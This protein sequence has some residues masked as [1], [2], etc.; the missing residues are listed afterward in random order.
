MS[1]FFFD[2]N[3]TY[4]PP[5]VETELAALQPD[6][7]DSPYVYDSEGRIA[8]AINMALAT[9]RPLMLLGP[10]GS[11]KSSLAK[12]VAH[13]FGWEYLEYVVTAETQAR[14]LCWHF[15]AVSRLADAQMQQTKAYH[16]VNYVEPRQLW[17]ALD[18]RGAHDQFMI[19]WEGRPPANARLPNPNPAGTVVLID[20]IDKA[21]PSVPNDLLIPLGSRE[22]TV[23]ETGQRVRTQRTTPDRTR[24]QFG[25]LLVV[26]TSNGERRMP[27]AFMRRC[28]SHVFQHPDEIQLIEIARAH[29]PDELANGYENIA[30]KLAEFLVTS[31]DKMSKEGRRAPGT[32]EYIDAIRAAVSMPAARASAAVETLARAMFEKKTEEQA[33]G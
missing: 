6:S 8:F 14:D 30:R 26:V 21:E 17:E 24:L 15:D 20:E 12:A 11:G 3:E 13:H 19:R 7:R 32:A 18:P 2:P 9:G 16:A 29:F 4:T 23:D 10:S 1:D 25:P 33:R 28:I 5:R 31:Q 27:E 22:F